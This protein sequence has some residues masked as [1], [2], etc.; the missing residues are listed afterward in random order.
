MILRMG[1][2]K[3]AK[4]Q[5]H[6]LRPRIFAFLFFAIALTHC[7]TEVDLPPD[8]FESHPIIHPRPEDLSQGHVL[9]GSYIVSFRPVTSTKFLSHQSFFHESISA[10]QYLDRRLHH[11]LR[12][13]SSRF[14]TTLY[15]ETFSN[16]REENEKNRHLLIPPLLRLTGTTTS[17]L[18][19]QAL[20]EINFQNELDAQ[21]VLKEWAEEGAI[22]YA[23]PN[24]ISFL[25]TEE[26]SDFSRLADQ[27]RTQN[28]WWANL[29]GLPEAFEILSQSA[30]DTEKNES[31][32]KPIVAILD[33]GVDYNHPA[34]K[35][36]I[37]N[38]PRVGVAGCDQDLH[39]CDTTQSSRGRLG[40]G[41]VWPFDL[42]GPGI[43]CIGKDPN[44]A[45]GTHVAGIIA[46]DSSWIP[47]GGDRGVLGVC[48]ICRI[49]ILKIV[50]KV[51]QGS[52]I[53]D[54]SIIS[55]LKYVSLFRNSE[56]NQVRI[57]N[58][59]F[60]KFSKSRAVATL[61]RKL[62]EGG[63]LVISAA[64][65]ENSMRREYPAAL[66]DGIAVTAIGSKIDKLAF[67]NYGNWVD[68]AAP[69]ES[70]AST[71]PGQI[72]A[73]KSGTSMAAPIVAGVA[74]LI[75]ANKGNISFD[76]F[77]GALLSSAS[78]DLYFDSQRNI[79]ETI[80]SYYPQVDKFGNHEP[81][82]GLGIVNA[83][84]A[85]R[86][87]KDLNSISLKQAER[88]KAGC[89]TITKNN[90]P[91]T[92]HLGIEKIIRFI[93]NLALIPALSYLIFTRSS[94]DTSRSS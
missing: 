25:S 44:C 80:S 43:S 79:R 64:G 69:G 16:P 47:P 9:P 21:T 32:H 84:A 58:A 54:S 78:P 20:L 45:H 86:G 82:L 29:I 33:S 14:L 18:I 66:S 77:K 19:S 88:V 40:K 57:I 12:I 52:G 35:N 34:L 6:T 30:W 55:A 65:N 50:S 90:R 61:I 72:I 87:K 1:L 48:P 89:G 3:S 2:P 67:S 91:I 24:G 59:S 76:E 26:I 60:G 63:T 46:A 62:R 36:R 4:S 10:T 51:G 68:I 83:S 41:T 5:A 92:E 74:G 7:G 42:G 28:E 75:L 85:L 53:L 22:W 56:G 23:E 73:A 49:M 71:V 17:P 8:A 81:L 93:W 37:W 11:D 94:R 31:T 70:I 15:Q 27:Y 38:N 13:K 39:G